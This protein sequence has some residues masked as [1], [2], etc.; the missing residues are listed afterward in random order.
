MTK[1]M[2]GVVLQCLRRSMRTVGGPVRIDGDLLERFVREGDEG[3]FTTLVQR[4]G[5]MVLAVAGRVLHDVHDAEDVFQATFLVLARKA[6]SIRRR[7][8]LA[9]WLY[10]VA[11]RIAV[12]LRAGKARRQARERRVEIMAQEAA[13]SDAGRHELRALLDEE[14]S[15]L[16]E[17][18]RTPL[19]H[20]FGRFPAIL[21]TAAAIQSVVSGHRVR[22]GTAAGIR[23]ARAATAA[24]R[25][26]PCSSSSK[27]LLL[28]GCQCPRQPRGR[29]PDLPIAE[30]R[31]RRGRAG[32]GITGVD[33]LRPCAG[34]F[35]RR[36]H[37]PGAARERPA[38]PSYGRRPPGWAP[39]ARLSELRCGR[40]QNG[41]RLPR[42]P[43]HVFC[44]DP[45][46]FA[47]N[48]N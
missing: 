18:Y 16:P 17:K 34:R 5:A 11:H 27:S 30:V 10:Q 6:R 48:L 45:F 14:L 7:Q 33:V 44:K 41:F 25:I 9:G 3:V 40:S 28:S 15:F 43:T 31:R 22:T 47:A 1:G 21:R 19:A 29:G 13:D 46:V 4:H 32:E 20:F 8:A 38:G 12:K 24:A 2:L 36:G 42:P 39:A 26:R 23:S 37:P 35:L